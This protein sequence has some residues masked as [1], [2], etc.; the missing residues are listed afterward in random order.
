MNAIQYGA[1][2]GVL[3]QIAQGNSLRRVFGTGTGFQESYSAMANTQADMQN[4][5]A[6]ETTRSAREHFGKSLRGGGSSGMSFAHAAK[7]N[8][9]LKHDQF[10][11]TAQGYSDAMAYA[12]AEGITGSLFQNLAKTKTSSM[13][14]GRTNALKTA[15]EKVEGEI[16]QI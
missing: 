14:D 2:A 3:N 7:S 12:K 15:M 9:D 11:G 5:T 10:A 16:G 8:A 6:R 1:E 4:Y 13:G